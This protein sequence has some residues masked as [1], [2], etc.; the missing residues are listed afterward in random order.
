MT[1][2]TLFQPDPL[3]T[4][5]LRELLGPI[6]RKKTLVLLVFSGIFIGG[7]LFALTWARRYYAAS[8]QVLVEQ[9]RANPT[10]TSVQNAAV[11]DRV[12]TPDEVSSEVALFSGHDIMLKVVDRCNLATRPS[13]GDIFLPRDPDLRMEAKREKAAV[14][15]AKNLDVETEKSS[16]IIDVSYGTTAGRDVPFCVLNTLSDLYIEKHLRVQRP[17]NSF[18]F[19]DQ[20]TD[21]YRRKLADSEAHLVQFSRDK[22]IAAPD[23]V[24]QFLAQELT[25]FMASGYQEQQQIA[26]DRRRV[27]ELQSDMRR[28]S[29]RSS[30]QE[31]TAPAATLLQQLQSNLVDA[32]SKR[33]QLLMKYSPSYPLV[34]EEDEEI[35]NIRRAIDTANTAPYETVTTDRDLNF[36]ALRQDLSKTQADLAANTASAAASAASIRDIR[37]QL[38][39]LDDVTVQQAALARQAKADEATYLLYLD[40]REQQRVSDA[41]DKS[42]IA[43]VSVA[44][45]PV[46]PTLTAYS[47]FLVSFVGFILAIVVGV[48]SGF[49]ADYL[50]PTFRMPSEVSDLLGVPVIASLPKMA[51]S[52]LYVTECY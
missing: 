46:V 24:R 36:E 23:V 48:A 15:L 41:L 4:T 26:A 42:Q 45:P 34:I 49:A 1:D 16:D 14:A 10:V 47:P 52:D 30:S 31:T 13:L 5:T 28:T 19:F 17:A 7:L 40:K 35:S 9:G 32:E 39:H 12:I 22:D 11:M 50:D 21:F 37:A 6:F 20:Q 2:A 29:P 44:V 8:M 43:N 38:V 3:T 18:S 33:S 25:T 51:N 27:R